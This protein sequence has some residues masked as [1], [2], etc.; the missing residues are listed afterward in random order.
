MRTS[1]TY[2]QLELAE[3]IIVRFQARSRG[4]LSRRSL[5][6]ERDERAN[7]GAWATALQATARGYANR[8]RFTKRFHAVHASETSVIG[9]QA[10]LRGMVARVRRSIVQTTL[11]KSVR[12]ITGLQTACRGCIARRTRKEHQQSLL[13]PQV[14]H[15]VTAIQA[16]LRGRLLRQASAEQQQVVTAHLATFTSLQSHLRGALVRRGRRA[17]EEK[18]DSATDC[19]VAI[20]SAAR[21]ILA[22]RKKQYFVLNIQ[23]TTPAVTSLQAIA[24][25]R[26]AKQAHSTMQKAL[27]KVE[28]AGSVGGLQAFLRTKLAKRQTTEQ[29]KK[30]EF[31]QPDVIG[32][33]AIARGYLARQEFREWRDYLQDPHTQGALIFL[34]SLVRGF[35]ARRRLYLRTSYIHRNVNKVMT[36][37]SLWRG[38]AERQMYDKLLTGVDVDVPTIQN[39]MHLLDDTDADYQRQIRTENMRKEVVTL[40]RENQSLETEV[41]ELDTKIA[42]ILKNKMT[43]EDLVRVEHNHANGDRHGHKESGS[44]SHHANRDPFT[45]GAHRDR[46]SQRKLELFEHLFFTLQTKGVYLSRLLHA[47]SRSEED[48][49]DR[50]LVDN[51]TLVLFGFGHERRE[52]YLFHRLLQVCISHFRH[53]F[54]LTR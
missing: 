11:D 53:L 52:E 9:V 36:I 33:Q 50:R 51:V 37:Q 3:P 20:Q 6:F 12:S 10:Q 16:V 8:R 35:I 29:K 34:Q 39:Y 25:A 17:Q 44:F 47:L 24:R 54:S 5:L 18:V 46:A 27:A 4:A 19:I 13:Q 28:V 38:R 14:A 43:F 21:G 22:R 15:S 30:L 31:V 23:R 40:I 2:T 41:K 45:T 26:L 7:L 1:R 49:K 42:L 32:F 48:E